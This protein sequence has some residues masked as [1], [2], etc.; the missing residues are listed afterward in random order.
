MFPAESLPRPSGR[1]WRW[2]TPWRARIGMNIY[3]DDTFC[4]KERYNIAMRRPAWTCLSTLSLCA[5]GSV[6]TCTPSRPRPRPL[7]PASSPAAPHPRPRRTVRP[8]PDHRPTVTRFHRNAL[9]LGADMRGGLRL[10]GRSGPARGVARSG[11]LACFLAASSASRHFPR[12]APPG[13]SRQ[14]ARPPRLARSVS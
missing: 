8:H 9:L 3:G 12:S 5:L 6:S 4:E 1:S 10:A 14:A 2:A 11:V 13:A 7:P